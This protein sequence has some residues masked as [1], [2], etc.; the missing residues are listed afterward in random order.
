MLDCFEKCTRQRLRRR[1]RQR[2]RRRQR[3]RHSNSVFCVLALWLFIFFISA[4]FLFRFCLF[5]F[6]S[7]LSPPPNALPNLHGLINHYMPKIN[8]PEQQKS[9]TLWYETLSPQDDAVKSARCSPN[10]R[11]SL[12]NPPQ[13]LS[14]APQIRISIR[15]QPP[16]IKRRTNHTLKTDIP[17]KIRSFVR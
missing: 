3:Q 2:R 15:N 1:G 10:L 13:W 17:C 8:L 4:L 5:C 7:C 16:K 11:K 6:G 12:P 14:E 9:P